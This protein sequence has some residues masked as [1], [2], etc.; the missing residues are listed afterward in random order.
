MEPVRLSNLQPPTSNLQL[1]AFWNQVIIYLRAGQSLSSPLSSRPS[2]AHASITQV[3]VCRIS[4][5]GIQLRPLCPHNRRSFDV[6]SCQASRL[7]PNGA[8]R[9]QDTPPCPVRRK[10]GRYMKSIRPPSHGTRSTILTIRLLALL[11]QRARPLALD[12]MLRT[13]RSNLCC[14]KR[15]SLI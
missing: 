4:T 3:L 2:L 14:A 10:R 6:P 5:S 9:N 12:P 1:P 8:F 15:P 13:R 7:L 11:P